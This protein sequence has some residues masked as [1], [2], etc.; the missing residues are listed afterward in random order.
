MPKTENFEETTDNLTWDTQLNEVCTKLPDDPFA[1]IQNDADQKPKIEQED[2]KYRPYETSSQDALIA[3][4][5]NLNEDLRTL[6]STCNFHRPW[7][8][9]TPPL[10][11]TSAQVLPSTSTE[12]SVPFKFESVEQIFSK[13]LSARKAIYEFYHDNPQAIQQL[14]NLEKNLPLDA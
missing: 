11:S 14:K 1:L 8:S 6:T 2:Y 7:T 3:F 10:P 9:P 12:T 4:L 13:S 5:E